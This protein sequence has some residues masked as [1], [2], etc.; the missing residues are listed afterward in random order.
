VLPGLLQSNTI[1]YYTVPVSGTFVEAVTIGG[2]TKS[3]FGFVVTHSSDPLLLA[4]DV[5]VA[6][7][8]KD[9][10]VFSAGDQLIL[11]SEKHILTVV[12]SGS[13]QTISVGSI[14]II[15]L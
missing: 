7:D 4:R 6:I 10:S 5:V 14:P 9:F 12:R 2:F 8:G 13:V 11:S 3:R 1:V 15:S